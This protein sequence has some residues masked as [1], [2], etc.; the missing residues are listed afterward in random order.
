MEGEE[1]IHFFK[2]IIIG[3]SCTGKSCLLLRFCNET[4]TREYHRTI[5][6]NFEPRKLYNF[7]GK[8]VR[9]HIW[10]TVG[11]NTEYKYP[12]FRNYNKLGKPSA[13][14]FLYDITNQSSFDNL[15][16][17][18][19]EYKTNLL[20]NSVPF[21]LLGTKTDL[22]QQ[23]VVSTSKGKRFAE[24]HNMDFMEVSA[25][26]GV[27]V[28]EAFDRLVTRLML[29]KGEITLPVDPTKSARTVVASPLQSS[30]P[31]LESA[32]HA[33]QQSKQTKTNCIIM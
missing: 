7:Y 32:H 23:R 33:Q 2:V 13:L 1:V 21:I 17:W 8:T 15:D 16:Y 29:E 11:S 25:L 9:L 12:L 27:G 18:V 6:A 19:E 26:E 30:S 28:E 24:K 5:S 3:D 4:F 22:E 20:T 31:Q 14:V 10:D